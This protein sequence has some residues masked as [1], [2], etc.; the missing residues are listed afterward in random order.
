MEPQGFFT[1]LLWHGWKG[2][3]ENRTW[4]VS[5]IKEQNEIEV[6]FLVP[7]GYFRGCLLYPLSY[8]C[9]FYLIAFYKIRMYFNLFLCFQPLVQCLTYHG[10]SINGWMNNWM[11]AYIDSPFPLDYYL[12]PVVCPLMFSRFSSGTI[13]SMMFFWTYSSLPPLPPSRTDHPLCVQAFWVQI[14]V[15]ELMH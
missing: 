15:I 6:R 11:T 7:W 5:G 12:S 9:L 2:K 4:E 3:G 10:H 13:F 8:D 14:F 1:V